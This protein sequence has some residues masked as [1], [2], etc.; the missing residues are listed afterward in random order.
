[1]LAYMNFMLYSKAVLTDKNAL[2]EFTI[3]KIYGG[4]IVK[5]LI[6]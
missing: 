4:T 6:E 1:M 2:Q 5:K 3:A